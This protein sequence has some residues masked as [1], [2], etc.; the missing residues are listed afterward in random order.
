MERTENKMLMHFLTD[1]ELIQ[2]GEEL[3]KLYKEI[4]VL[5]AEKKRLSHKIKGLD[6]QIEDL[7]K[8]IDAKEEERNVL[9]RWVYNWKK[10]TK[11][12]IRT[13]TGEELQYD[14]IED[15]ERQQKLIEP[16]NEPVAQNKCHL[17][18][19]VCGWLNLKLRRFDAV[20]DPETCFSLHLPTP[21]PHLNTET[22]SNA[23]VCA[24]C[25]MVLETSPVERQLQPAAQKEL[26][27]CCTKMNRE[28]TIID[29]IRYLHCKVCGL[30]Y[31][32][33]DVSNSD[34]PKGISFDGPQYLPKREAA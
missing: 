22:E 25:G 33:W 11:H 15:W 27:G 30:V 29:N 17:L 9:C 20:C 6:E 3:V 1:D 26:P 14:L 31:R 21:C 2:K 32:M 23:V 24:D 5:D 8:I 12:L 13:D 28:H 4:S 7:I 34:R 19:P 10:G 16:E 18:D